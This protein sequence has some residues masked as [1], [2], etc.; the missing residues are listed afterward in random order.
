VK[1]TYCGSMPAEEVW[2]KIELCG[3]QPRAGRY[4]EFF[5]LPPGFVPG[6]EDAPF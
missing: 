1:R 5:V 6:D 2:H 3:S 4:G